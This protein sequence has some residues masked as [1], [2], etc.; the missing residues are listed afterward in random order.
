MR[1]PLPCFTLIAAAAACGPVRPREP[2]AGL[3]PRYV[4]FYDG[5]LPRCPV[6]EVGTLRSRTLGGFRSAARQLRAHAVILDRRSPDG[7]E[8]CEGT[9]VVFVREGCYQ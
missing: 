4:R 3:D 7:N 6:R 1:A 2:N 8:P 5:E 9:A